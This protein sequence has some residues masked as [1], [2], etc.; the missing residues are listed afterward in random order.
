M[1]AILTHS[2]VRLLATLALTAPLAMLLG[3]GGW[4]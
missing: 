4:R 3:G 2:S 1:K